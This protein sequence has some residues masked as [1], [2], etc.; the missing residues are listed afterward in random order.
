MSDVPEKESLQAMRPG[1]QLHFTPREALQN[2]S[3]VIEK[4]CGVYNIVRPF[5]KWASTFFLIPA[6]WK[7]ILK[8]FITLLDGLCPQAE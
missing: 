1:G 8:E 4:V 6:K 5:V 7:R 2:P 3:K